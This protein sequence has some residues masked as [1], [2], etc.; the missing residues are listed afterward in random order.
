MVVEVCVVQIV[1]FKLTEIVNANKQA[2]IC[3]VNC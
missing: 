1:L 2:I 3:Q